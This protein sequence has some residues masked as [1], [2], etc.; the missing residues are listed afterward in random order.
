MGEG[1]GVDADQLGGQHIV[2]DQRRRIEQL[3][4]AHVLLGQGRQLLQA[5]LQHQTLGL[6]LLVLGRQFAARA[7]FLGGAV[8]Q[9]HR[10]TAE[11]VDRLDNQPQLAAQRLQHAES[12]IH[13][14]QRSREHGEHQQAHTQRRTFGK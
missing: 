7:E 11:P 14:H 2:V 10:Q 13:H 12:R 4:Q 6:E 8:P 1:V 9:G 5:P 3:A